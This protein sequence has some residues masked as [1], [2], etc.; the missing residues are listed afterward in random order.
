MLEI[1]RALSTI[2][3]PLMED[4]TLRRSAYTRFR[5]QSME[6]HHE[7]SP[8]SKDRRLDTEALEL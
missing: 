7:G 3:D 2:P 4:L 1:I 8:E 5:D 6:V